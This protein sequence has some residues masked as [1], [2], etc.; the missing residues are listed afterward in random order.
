MQIDMNTPV[1]HADSIGWASSV[2]IDAPKYNK[3]D[4]S[5]TVECEVDDRNALLRGM[6]G[7]K[8]EIN[9]DRYLHMFR[10]AT[11]IRKTKKYAGILRLKG[12]S[13]YMY[14]KWK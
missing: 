9:V 8:R 3:E 12:Y 1:L 5:F 14:K 7:I 6:M 2:K 10:R 11:S 13:I 4:M